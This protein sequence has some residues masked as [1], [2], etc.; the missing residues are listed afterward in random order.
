[1]TLVDVE[2]STESEREEMKIECNI[3]FNKHLTFISSF[4]LKILKLHLAAL[5][6][7]TGNVEGIWWL[8]Q[9]KTHS[10]RRHK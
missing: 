3:K 5:E 9:V 7:E 10:I 1:M 4:S 2:A 6:T 8:R